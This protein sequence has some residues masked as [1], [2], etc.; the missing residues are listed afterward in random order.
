M[1]A[2]YTYSLYIS[3]QLKFFWHNWLTNMWNWNLFAWTLKGPL[4]ESW[5]PGLSIYVIMQVYI[6]ILC[7][8]NYKYDLFSIQSF[9][10]FFFHLSPLTS[11]CFQCIPFVQFTPI[12][13][14]KRHCFAYWKILKL[15][16]DWMELDILTRLKID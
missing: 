4:F 16:W 8:Q 7:S 15:Q 1:L 9:K 14:P 12:S 3:H 2:W 11:L 10:F 13:S 6:F 5:G